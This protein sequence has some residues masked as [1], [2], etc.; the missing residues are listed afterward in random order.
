MTPSTTPMRKPSTVS[1]KVTAICCH[2]GPW[3][4]PCVTQVTSWAQ[5]PEGRPQKKGSMRPTWVHS[6]QPPMSTTSSSRRRLL[7]RRR[8]RRRAAVLAA[9]PWLSGVVMASLDSLLIAF[10]ANHHLVAQI[11]PDLMIQLH[12]TRLKADFLHLA[13]PGQINCIDALDSGRPSRENADPIG[14]GDGLL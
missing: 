1:S 8:R 7:T 3:A 12:K 10:I 4:V 5:M 9:T 2:K 11:F 6:S 13:R 14:Q